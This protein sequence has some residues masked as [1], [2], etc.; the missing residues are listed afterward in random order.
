M[1]PTALARN[2]CCVL[3]LAQIADTDHL[4]E[5]IDAV[6]FAAAAAESSEIFK[7]PVVVH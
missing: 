7:I 4:S 6:G 5:R 2:A 3:P 1:T